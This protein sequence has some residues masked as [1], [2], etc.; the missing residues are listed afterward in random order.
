MGKMFRCFVNYITNTTHI[1]SS[2]V[3]DFW[4]LKLGNRVSGGNRDW[5]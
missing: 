3:N 1:G 2:T 5:A 4:L